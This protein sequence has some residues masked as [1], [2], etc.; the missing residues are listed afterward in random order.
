MKDLTIQKFEK[1]KEFVKNIFMKIVSVGEIPLGSEKFCK[2]FIGI[3]ASFIVGFTLLVFWLDPYVYYHKAWGI[4]QVYDVRSVAIIPGILRHFDY[5]CVLIGSSMTQNFYIDR[6]NA[7]LNVNCIKATSAGLTGSALDQYLNKALYSGKTKLK[8]VLIGMDF[9]ALTQDKLKLWEPYHYLYK[10]TIFPPEYF[11]SSDTLEALWKVI[12]VN[13]AYPFSQKMRDDACYNTMFCNERNRHKYGRKY[14]E[15][16]VR[17]MTYYPMGNPVVFR[18][19]LENYILKYARENPEVKFDLFLP[20]YSV[21]LWN[22]LEEFNTLDTFCSDRNFLAQE[23]AK[24]PNIRLHDF[25]AE[26]KIICNLDLYKDVTH[27]S[28]AVNDWIL[29]GIASGKYIC[30]KNEFLKRTERIKALEKK[31]RKEFD[32]LRVEI[33]KII[34]KK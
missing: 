2:Y 8:R 33:R 12:R 19:N 3:F 11:Y 14:I 17:K 29:E 10:D 27:Y 20:P 31:Y 21:Y 5:D 13:I 23:V 4:R 16:Y 1:I 22:T 15:N 28:P 32:S 18:K 25:H 9:F 26:E 6:I 34:G 7:A 30:K 24:Y